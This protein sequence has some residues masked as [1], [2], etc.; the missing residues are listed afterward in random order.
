M[1]INISFKEFKKNH[2]KK[3]IKFYLERDHVKNIIK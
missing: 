3:N 1:K 2:S